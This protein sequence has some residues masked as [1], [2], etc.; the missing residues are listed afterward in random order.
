VLTA[1]LATD[2]LKK[3]DAN[4]PEFIPVLLIAAAGMI[5]MTTTGNLVAMFIGIEIMSVSLYILSAFRRGNL[6]SIESGL[7]Y[8]LAGAFASGL[9]LMGIALN[10][11][12][13]GGFDMASLATASASGSMASKTAL[14]LILCGF[15]F[16]LSLAPFH[17]WAADVYEGARPPSPDSCRRR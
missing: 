15:A 7:K 6:R 16:K 17:Q 9:F 4:H 1:L 3:T 8:F 5:V 14:I 10:Y 13:S 2:W 12:V 11:G